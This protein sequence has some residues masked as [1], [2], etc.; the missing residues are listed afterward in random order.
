MAENQSFHTMSL[1][2][3]SASVMIALAPELKSRKSVS[4]PSLKITPFSAM[5]DKRVR[6]FLAFT[7]PK[8]SFASEALLGKFLQSGHSVSFSSVN[9]VYLIVFS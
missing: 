6:G 4:I 1:P 3:F 2:C 5:R 7:S 8:T 9:I